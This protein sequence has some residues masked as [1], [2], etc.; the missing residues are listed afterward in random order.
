[1]TTKTSTKTKIAETDIAWMAGVIDLRGKV[2]TKNNTMRATPPI[3]LLVESKNH[4]VVEKLCKLTGQRVEFHTEKRIR[5]FVRRACDIHCPVP[6]VHVND[7][8]AGVMV[9]EMKRWTIT[10]AGI[11][12]IMH[13]MLEYLTPQARDKYAEISLGIIDNTPLVGQGSGMVNKTIRR[14]ALLG[15]PIPHIYKSALE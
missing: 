2:V 9:P 11:V 5:E 13:S 1:M 8:G 12:V 6:H 4:Q 3:I 10:G 14:L 15:W 7:E